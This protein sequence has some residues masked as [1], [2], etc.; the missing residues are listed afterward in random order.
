MNIFT[1]VEIYKF[2][3]EKMCKIDK[4][5]LKFYRLYVLTNRNVYDIITL[6]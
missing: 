3:S 1:I 4:Q 5:Q 2:L 6:I